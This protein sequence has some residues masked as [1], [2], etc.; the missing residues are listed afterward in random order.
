MENAGSHIAQTSHLELLRQSTS[1]IH[2][3]NERA[4]VQGTPG[5]RTLEGD[6]EDLVYPERLPQDGEAGKTSLVIHALD[7]AVGIN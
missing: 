1:E 3:V 5:D 6:E 2:R 4:A 7:G